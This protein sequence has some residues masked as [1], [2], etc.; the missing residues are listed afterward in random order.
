MTTTPTPQMSLILSITLLIGVLLAHYLTIEL[1]ARFRYLALLFALIALL[2]TPLWFAKFDGWF[3]AVKIFSVWVPLL[4]FGLIKALYPVN[5][6]MKKWANGFARVAFF[7]LT[8]NIL[9]ASV[10]GLQAG[11]FFNA[12]VGFL[13]IV[14]LP[15]FNKANWIAVNYKSSPFIIYAETPFKYILLYSTWN[16]CFVYS[17]FPQYFSIVAISLIYC[18]LHVYVSKSP[19]LWFSFRTF[20][21]GL[22]LML[23]ANT[24]WVETYLDW[25]FL[26]DQRVAY[27]WGG[28][29]LSL[30]LAY[31]IYTVKK[32][33]KQ[34]LIGKAVAY[35]P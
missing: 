20:T 28:M 4:I 19:N 9:E 33:L 34:S 13:L 35:F 24:Y 12:T 15:T 2:S 25:S 23:R 18:L 30:T 14:I 7:L 31:I 5:E 8:L 1:I 29:N 6:K 10:N 32:E 11:Y 22:I 17:V 3:Y 27:F 26:Y 21:L 16:I